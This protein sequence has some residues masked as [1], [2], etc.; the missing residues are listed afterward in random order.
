MDYLRE[1]GLAARYRVAPTPAA[2]ADVRG[3]R[4]SWPQ[5]LGA[6]DRRGALPPRPPP[7]RRGGGG[8]GGAAR[9]AGEAGDGARDARRVGVAVGVGGGAGKAEDDAGGGSGHERGAGAV[10]A[11]RAGPGAESEAGANAGA[12]D[13]P[14]GGGG[15]TRVVAAPREE[16][17][18]G[19]E[20]GSKKTA[21]ASSATPREEGTGGGGVGSTKRVFA[22]SA[23]V[24]PTPR[25][26]PPPKRRLVSAERRFPPGCGR[27]VDCAGDGSR[28]VTAAPAR[29]GGGSA[30]S[31]TKPAAAAAVAAV[32]RHPPWVEAGS[33]GVLEKVSAAVDG[34]RLVVAPARPG[35]G[36]AASPTKLAA[37]H[38]SVGEAGSS[39]V[40]K[41]ASAA[42]DSSR[43]MVAPARGGGS[44]AASPTKP[45]AAAHR[46]VGDACSRGVLKEMS[47]AAISCPVDDGSRHSPHAV[48]L[49]SLE[50]SRRSGMA[51]AADGLL[52]TDSHVLS[53]RG[54]FGSGKEVVRF[55]PRPGA[56]SAIRR[57]PPGC[58]RVKVSL[59]IN[60]SAEKC[61][62]TESK[63]SST[64]SD[65]FGPKKKVSVKGPDH[66]RLEVASACTM[67]SISN[68]DDLVDSILADDAF[69]NAEDAYQ[70]KLQ[71]KL[72]GSSDARSKF[73]MICGRFQFICKA[74][75]QFVEQRSL[76][77][78]R[79]DIAAS[80]VIKKLPGFTQL[81]PVIGDVPGVEVGDEF[82]YRVQLAL[83]GLHRPLQ[84]GID[85]MKDENG[86]LVAISVVASGGYP[87]ELSSS[88]ELI[89]T[90]FGGKYAGKKSDENQKLEGGNLALKNCIQT[91]TPVRVI[92]GFKSREEGSHSRAKGAIAFTYDGL[93]RVVDYWREGQAGSKVFKYKLL[94]IPDQPELS[95]RSKTAPSRKTGIMC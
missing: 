34:P 24:A 42:V 52:D 53:G 2:A 32:P 45:S 14:G 5:R 6:G 77:I 94:R 19:V 8:G 11:P 20:E 74:I 41:K 39:G 17:S 43:L 27:G 93:Y 57:F 47:A 49:K 1:A 59:P 88:G 37:A 76:K 22:S 38:R 55:L 56:I 92:H 71:L 3:R 54:G 60:K 70:K 72:N 80:K 25:V 85:S 51:A 18:G 36:C 95:H 12:A 9:D 16:G 23:A 69:L 87:D 28:L 66:I 29:P 62:E 90:G 10:V 64:S 26:Y 68:M 35:G 40:L 65:S 86:V 73:K 50:A 21:L 79:I 4:S 44:C 89:Y 46:S 67:G 30:A 81:G 91:M 84:P 48:A 15:A 75:L 63:D 61:P 13:V 83:V 7:P 33:D 78:S 31:P 58:G 82:V